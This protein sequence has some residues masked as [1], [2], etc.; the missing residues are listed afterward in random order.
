MKFLWRNAIIYFN[1][2]LSMNHSFFNTLLLADGRLP[3]GGYS[4]SAGLEPAVFA[5]LTL[6]NAYDYMSARLHTA[7]QMETAACVLA[8]RAVKAK[9][10]KIELENIEHS[11][12]ARMPSPAQR[13]ASH[14]MGRA[15]LYL[16]N[17]LKEEDYGIQ[18]LNDL[19]GP[20][21]RGVALGVL[22]QALNVSEENCAIACC[23]D[24]MQ[25]ITEAVLKLLPTDPTIVTKWLV[26]IGEEVAVVAQAAQEVEQPEDLPAVSAPWMEH[27]AEDHAYRHKRLFMA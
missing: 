15:I 11:V 2:I 5:G 6:N 21:S 12:A 27:W 1:C 25:R 24:D 9:T 8:Y 20:P 4:D 23:Y 22:A 18:L 10:D 16:G 14:F 3:T 19:A 26:D 13:K 17:R 7:T